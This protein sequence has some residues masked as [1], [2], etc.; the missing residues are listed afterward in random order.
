MDPETLQAAVDAA[1]AQW[2]DRPALVTGDDAV[3]F[4]DLVAR[5]NQVAHALLDTPGVAPGQGHPIGMCLHGP[6]SVIA[7]L[8]I[9]K[10]GNPYLPLDPE[11]PV[12]RIRR[13]VEDTDLSLIVASAGTVQSGVL[14]GHWFPGVVFEIDTEWE[15]VIRRRPTTPPPLLDTLGQDSLAYVLYTSGSSGAPKG[16][17]GPHR[18]ALNRCRW[19]WEAFPFTPED[20]CI[21]KTAYGFVDHVFET[22]GPLGQGVPLVVCPKAARA[23]TGAL[24]RLMGRHAVTRL[25]AV[26]SLLRA[27]TQLGHPLSETVPSLRLCVSSGEPLTWTLAQSFHAAAP[28]VRL[29]NLYGSTEV[30]GDVTWWE[31]PFDSPPTTAMVPAGRPI[32]N[33]TVKILDE[34]T[35][36]LPAR[37]VGEVVVF[38]ANLAAGYWQ[39]EDPTVA[40]FQNLRPIPGGFQRCLSGEPVAQRAYFTGDMG[41]IDAD[42]VLHLRGRKDQQVKVRGYRVDLLE[43]EAHLT[44]CEG[45]AAACALVRD[46]P[47]KLVTM[48]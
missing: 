13:M 18:A 39:T 11:Y 17:L 25:I 30:A 43:V 32:S 10:T 3:S 31:V 8:G 4:N 16:V 35:Q 1:A 41:L 5:S 12:A 46:D 28:T 44:A 26:P 42:G 23:D 36:E 27:L 38:G 22:F 14:A 19:M 29:L 20:V 37:E 15:S 48:L 40:R 6:L 21:Q 47:P 45:V 34:D 2:P 7:L 24:V 9:L 33:T